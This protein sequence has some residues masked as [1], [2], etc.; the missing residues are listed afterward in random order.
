MCCDLDR[1]RKTYQ[2]SATEYSEQVKTL[3]AHTDSVLQVE[4]MLLW[5]AA[6]TAKNKCVE[7]HRILQHHIAE[8]DCSSPRI[9][10]F[11]A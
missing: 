3:C 4:Y 9:K 11:R 7:T 2:Q 5:R 8:H 10:A 6:E 1:L